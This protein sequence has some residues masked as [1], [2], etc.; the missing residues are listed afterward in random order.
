MKCRVDHAE[1]SHLSSKS[2][3][4][5]NFAVIIAVTSVKEVVFLSALVSLLGGLCK[6]YLTDFRKIL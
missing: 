6:N 2:E 3:T 5:S 4:M 1:T